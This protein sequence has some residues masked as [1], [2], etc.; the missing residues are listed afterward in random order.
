MWTEAVTKGPHTPGDRSLL[1]GLR[2]ETAWLS[3][4][5]P[6]HTQSTLIAASGL[7]LSDRVC[8]GATRFWGNAGSDSAGL[9]GAQDFI[10]HQ[11][12]VVPMLP[13]CGPPVGRKAQGQ[14][15]SNR[16]AHRN[17]MRHFILFLL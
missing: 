17:P 5:P 10:S 9:H 1:A 3:E 7:V 2:Q 14:W 6:T 11:L 15:F 13:F 16:G 12:L 4:G 8:P